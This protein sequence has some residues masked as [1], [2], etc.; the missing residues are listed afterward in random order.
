MNQVS[1][2]G[3]IA[4]EVEVKK[5]SDRNREKIINVTFSVRTKRFNSPGQNFQNDDL[6]NC[7]VYGKEAEQIFKAYRKGANIAATGRLQVNEYFDDNGEVKYLP[8]I[9]VIE[10][11][12]YMGLRNDPDSDADGHDNIRQHK[13]TTETKNEIEI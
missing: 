6:I 8:M 4:T 12:E 5:E 7:I 10:N 13:E 9:V 11:F 3:C 2:S 1:I